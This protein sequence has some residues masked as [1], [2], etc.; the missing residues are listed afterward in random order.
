MA[1]LLGRGMA[2][3]ERGFLTVC[4]DLSAGLTTAARP[5]ALTEM[6]A[7]APSIPRPSL[8][9]LRPAGWRDKTINSLIDTMADHS[10]V[11]ALVHKGPVRLFKQLWTQQY[12]S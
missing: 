5:I 8:A 12:G 3:V 9:T 6:K 1:S 11:S 4:M 2:A 7:S 10:R